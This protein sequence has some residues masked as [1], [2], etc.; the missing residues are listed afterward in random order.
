MKRRTFVGIIFVVAGL[1]KLTDMWGLTHFSWIWN[2]H[3]TEY[4]GPAL[5]LIVGFRLIISNMLVDRDQWLQ[6]PVPI[7]EDG[8]RILCSVGFGGDEYVYHGEPFHGARLEAFCGGI[9]LDLRQA[10]INEDEAIDI[11][12]CIGGVELLVPKGIN[13]FVK[14]RSLIG[15]VGN[16]TT[17][18]TDK[19]APCLYITASNMLGGVCIRNEEES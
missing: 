5:L 3:W 7:N 6:R 11:S 1:W 14:S 15:G 17:S 19:N 12:T 9:R 18:S 10:T 4:I 13:V 2:Q 16:H 8:K